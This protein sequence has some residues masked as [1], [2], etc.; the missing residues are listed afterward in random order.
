MKKNLDQLLKEKTIP[1]EDLVAELTPTQKRLMESFGRQ[2]DML[3][4]LRKLR[5]DLGLTQEELAKKADIPRT[6][7][8]KIESGSYNPTINTLVE[9]AS[10]LDKKLEINFV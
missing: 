4:A 6:T 8:S 1:F 5:K 10:A 9:I 3:V 7:I 2:Y